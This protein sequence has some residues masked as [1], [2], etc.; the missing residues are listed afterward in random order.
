MI[1]PGGAYRQDVVRAFVVGTLVA[2]YAGV[3]FYFHSVLSL[4]IVYTHFAYIPIALAGLWWGRK[5]ILVALA[6]V[7]I[8][9]SLRGVGSGSG[10]LW[11]DVARSGFFL[12]AAACIGLLG[13]R[14]V[15]SRQAALASEEKY[16][17]L[18]DQSLAGIFVHR[19][20]EIK[21]VNGRLCGM[22]GY[23][24]EE[25]LGLAVARIVDEDDRKGCL[26]RVAARAQAAGGHYEY[27]LVRRDGER[28]WVEL[29][30]SPTIFEGGPA[31]LVNVYDISDRKEA[32]A[33]REELQQLARKQEEQLV[34][35]GRL[36]ELGEMAASIAHEINQPLTVM[37]VLAKNATY[38]MDNNVG[39]AAEIKGNLDRINEQVD[40]AS[41]IINQIRRLTRK[42][43]P[44]FTP[45]D[46]NAT[47]KESVEFLNPQFKLHGIKVSLDL[48]PGLPLIQGDRI[49]LE[50]VFL[51]ILTNSRQ[52]M[53][54]VAERRLAVKTYADQGS[55]YPVIVEITDSGEG[56][57]P[58]KADTLFAPFY[59][60]KKAGEG[61]GLGLSISLTIIKEHGG[62]IEAIGAPG[63]GS[64]FKVML[65]ASQDQAVS[66]GQAK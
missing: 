63:V 42:S 32:E 19:D 4:L 43:E 49:R 9:F 13:E 11:A 50:Q 53:E 39:G 17:L 28:V 3:G 61:T 54:N 26:E 7:V 66:E 56:F 44:L 57:A 41:R 27:R 2:A 62:D 21:F 64:I 24:A 33:K 48:A 31:V 35:S 36:A 6:L 15:R 12:V 60:T 59:S 10:A 37:K 46:L 58:E 65:P 5:S 38:M 14:V 30:C 55:Q 29:G 23:G 51:N 25:L 52:A 22:L 8:T 34:H 47:V 18:I 1:Q 40:R 45:L 20:L 16:R